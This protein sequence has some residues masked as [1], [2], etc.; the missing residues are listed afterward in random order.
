MFDI[1]PLSCDFLFSTFGT[2]NRVIVVGGFASP[3]SFV[4]KTITLTDQQEGWIKAQVQAGH[5]ASNS[6]C[7]GDLIRRD[8]KAHGQ[9]DAM[10]A[11]L[12]EGESSGSPQDFDGPAF[13]TRMLARTFACMPAHGD[14][15]V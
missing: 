10:R 15:A 5:Y 14:G 7:I 3:V 1:Y 6:A 13:K 11:A 8:W 4:R 12:L 9:L 2:A